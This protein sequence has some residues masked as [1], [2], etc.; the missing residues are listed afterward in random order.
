MKKFIS[1]L[2]SMLFSVLLLMMFAIS[3]AYATFIENDYG[4]PTA[5][6]LIYQAWWFEL[7]LLLG[8]I[9]LSGSVFKY[10]LVNRKKWAILLFH[11]A[12]IFILI[13]AG[14]TRYF[15]FEGSMHIREGEATNKVVSEATFIEIKASTNGNEVRKTTQVRFTPN[16][17]NKFKQ[18]IEIDGK[19]V[20]IENEIFV[21]NASGIIVP[22]PNGLPV[23]S[24][25]VSTGN[26]Q[27]DE[28]LLFQQ[29]QMQLGDLTFGF[30]TPANSAKVVFR[31]EGNGISMICSDTVLVS[32]MMGQTSEKLLPQVNY[33]VKEK[34]FY[35]LGRSGFVVKSYLPSA[36]PS[37]VQDQENQT[38]TDAFTARIT[39]GNETRVVNVFGTHGSVSEP[40]R[41]TINGVNLA[42]TYGSIARELPFEIYLRDFQL[43][44]YPGSNSPSSYASEITL[45]DPA[46]SVERPFRI[47][48]NNILKYQ[49]YRFF[50]SAFDPDE[51]GTILS[52]NHDYWGTMIS[53]LGYFLMT[54]GM[55]FTVFSKGS[56]FQTLI[57][58]SSK[59]QAARQTIKIVMAGLIIS[60]L[61]LSAN[62]VSGAESSSAKAK[63]V[64]E[65]GELLVQDHQGRIEP[66]NTLASDLLRKITKK[67][68]WQGLSAVEF[69]LEMS[70]NPERWKNEPI[71]KVANP[72]L[73][74]ML[75][76][77]DDYTSFTRMFDQNGKYRLNDLVQQSY[78]K[79]QTSRN[80]LDKEIINVDERLNICYQIFNGD[81][82][83][84]FP[85]PGDE[86]KTWATQSTLPATLNKEQADFTRG[87]L[88]M[89]YAEYN[90]SQASGNWSKPAEYLG[91]I[92]K[93]QHTYGADII[94]SDSKVKL[95]IVYNEWNI[96]G[97]LAKIYIILGFALLVVHFMLIFKPGAKFAKLI[98][99]GSLLIFFAFLLYTAGL[100][101][102]WYISG[103]APWS[104]G[105]ETM[106]YVGWAT[107]LSGFIFM[108][109]SPITLAVT[110]IL[111]AII[112]F[113]AGMSWMNPEITNLVP[114]LKSYWL[115]VHVAIITASYGFLAMGAL[116]G[117]LNL[118]LIILRNKQ[119]EK[120]IGF[121]ILEV[122]YIIEMAL[123]IGL[124]MLTIGSFIGGVWANES[125]G[126]Y[127]GWDPK[128]TW[129]LVTV[130]VYSII[131][132]LR[133][134]PGLKSIFALSSL[135]LV[136]LGSVLMTF[137]GVN[138]YLSGMHS[139][140]QGDPPPIPSALYV[141]IIMIIVVIIV[142][143]YREQKYGAISDP[144]DAKD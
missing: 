93:Y 1:F 46:S 36:V 75:G 52:V 110:T 94:P 29:D 83:K 60:A 112:L 81:F 99:G 42:L 49:G 136:G 138:Y 97:K 77:S 117:L 24:L 128:E 125:W 142:A 64:A 127:W 74:K 21:P 32:G 130:L 87:I 85:I 62:T 86:R 96:F 44:R 54:L 4:T 47:F 139:Y 27:R 90:N 123:I 37:L 100:A 106:I 20:T 135:A 18:S 6:A 140:A 113:V 105:Y 15:G 59:L 108:R 71:V 111:A 102:R 133:K 68:S 73:K 109:R 114:V 79:K 31:R 61:T 2:F 126:R 118:F 134:V 40:V 51:K 122:S 16:T 22:A 120:Q 107:S 70:A 66:V 50:Q 25:L 144:E 91:Y 121:T 57:R 12:F 69:F 67:N 8:I 30:E 39:S 43:E 33:S 23:V 35:V 116:L 41:C 65:F 28:I 95:E 141:A 3:I 98:N 19:K 103:H 63:H 34:Q 48:M 137:F 14:V 76:L 89:Y 9:N 82:L 13:G 119:N 5:Q 53:Y 132:H 10:K 55:V 92:K 124:F 38:G 129:A 45:K 72:E 84:I 17:T 80:K 131:L 104:N 7:L 101:I 56:R 78:N 26:E 88:S 143:R 11:L 115:I 58:L